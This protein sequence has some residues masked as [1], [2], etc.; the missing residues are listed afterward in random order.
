MNMLTE[1]DLDL[2]RLQ[3]IMSGL[4]FNG[5]KEIIE[6]SSNTLYCKFGEKKKYNSKKI[7]KLESEVKLEINN[8]IHTSDIKKVRKDK[9]VQ[10]NKIL[11]KEW[12]LDDKVNIILKA[13]YKKDNKYVDD[14]KVEDIIRMYRFN[15]I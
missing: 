5:D 2:I 6:I 12:E 15:L 9:T 10:P 1:K 3:D 7:N 8:K 11:T 4:G 13:Y 14:N